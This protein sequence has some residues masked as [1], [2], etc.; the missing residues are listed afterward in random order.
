MMG[1]VLAGL[2]WILGGGTYLRAMAGD[3]QEGDPPVDGLDAGIATVWPLIALA[4]LVWWLRE[5][6]VGVRQPWQK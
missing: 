2:L 3:R 6:A 4:A 1:W 5:L